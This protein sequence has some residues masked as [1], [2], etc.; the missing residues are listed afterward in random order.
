M[1]QRYKV[2]GETSVDDQYL[3]LVIVGVIWILVGV[4]MAV[5]GQARLLGLWEGSGRSARIFGLVFAL[6]GL[7][8]AILGIT[9]WQFW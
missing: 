7:A 8:V 2:S 5:T 1:S 4:G 6:L 3:G 9:L